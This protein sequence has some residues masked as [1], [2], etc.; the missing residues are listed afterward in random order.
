MN[1]REMEEVEGVQEVK[2]QGGLS[3]L[4]MYVW[5]KSRLI[6]N[7]VVMADDIHDACARAESILGDV[8]VKGAPVWVELVDKVQE[9]T[10]MDEVI[11]SPEAIE[12]WDGLRAF[13]KCPTSWRQ[14]AKVRREGAVLNVVW[15]KI[16]DKGKRD[17]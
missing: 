13:T 15:E 1:G 11:L 2:W 16:I 6:D 9:M 17:A 10:V 4:P 7:G 3:E 8:K 14:M 5:I 12:G